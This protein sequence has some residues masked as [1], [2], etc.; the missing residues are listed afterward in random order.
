MTMKMSHSTQYG[1]Q[2]K[3]QTGCTLFVLTTNAAQE[4]K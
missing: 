4:S 1:F 2:T 3:Q